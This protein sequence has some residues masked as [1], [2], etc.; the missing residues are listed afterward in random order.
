M[1]E[2]TE[3]AP[4]VDLAAAR[5]ERRHDIREARLAEVRTAF[6]KAFPLPAATP[7]KKRRTKKKAKK[8]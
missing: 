6:E 2:S 3:S 8:R 5:H 7:A 1:S 4:V